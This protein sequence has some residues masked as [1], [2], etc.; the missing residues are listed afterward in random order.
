MIDRE[1]IDCRG[2]RERKLSDPLCADQALHAHARGCPPCAHYAAKLEAFERDLRDC[3]TVACKVPTDLAQSIIE[4]CCGSG[5]KRSLF[6]A[7]VARL[8]GLGPRSWFVPATGALATALLL[9]LAGMVAFDVSTRPEPL[10]HEVIAHVLSEPDVLDMRE[11]VPAEAVQAAFAGIG[12]RLHRA[13]GEV[14][15]LGT[16]VMN[17]QVVQHLLV[18][19]PEGEVSLILLS[20]TLL[21]SGPYSSQGMTS[22][23]LPLQRGSIGIVTRSAD[24]ARKIHE[25]ITGAVTVEG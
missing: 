18:Q 8:S 3:A 17:G 20:G 15:F 13:I 7:L 11:D 1:N 10:A 23:L 5:T 12:G 9:G 22:V 25:R 21:D 19:T 4:R 24:T 14:R 6:A 16:C 2:F